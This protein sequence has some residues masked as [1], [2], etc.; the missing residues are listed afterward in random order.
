[1]KRLLPALALL[2]LAG[3]ARA[4][5]PPVVPHFIHETATAGIDSVYA[6][7]W[8]YMVGGGAAAFD[9]NDDG[10]PDLLLAGGEKPAGFFINNSK[11]GGALSFARQ[12]S[13][14]EFE[15][16]TGAYPI[17]I[18][19][20]GIMDVVVLRVGEN[21]VMKGEG[22]C[23]FTRA[24]E[25]WGFDGGDAWSTAFA[26]SWE[27]GAQ[28]PSL[29][30]GNYID[31]NEELEPWGSCTPNWLHRPAAGG[32]GFAPPLPLTP[33]YCP[34]S[35][36]FTDWSNSGAADLRVSN[37]REYYEG[38]QE[39]MWH[40]PAGKPPKLYSK[41]EGWRYL[42]IWGMG[43]AAYDLNHD[44]YQEYFLT[45]MAD[46][47]L[48]TLGK[49]PPDG[50]PARPDYK[51][52]AWP[53]GVTA[54]RPFMGGDLRPS[55]AWHTEF[56]DVNNDGLADLFVAKG[57][58]S[59]M[60]D[61]AMADPNNLLVQGADGKFAEMADKAGVASV[62][63]ARGGAVVDFNLD[64]L[65]DLLVVN[66]NSAAEIWRNATPNAGN[67]LALRLNQPG[68][69]RDG[70]GAVVEIKTRG[71]VQRREITAGGGHVSG[72]AGWIHAGIGA[73][74][75]AEV[76]VRWPGEG[77]SSAITVPANSFAIVEKAAATPRLWQPER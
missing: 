55:T 48:Q 26:A 19:S 16:V 53:A 15:A 17:D 74:D 42:R 43:I 75:Q 49:P 33:S 51:D 30:I 34:L 71:G 67:W 4:A 8:Q 58:V 44:G 69:N 6:G 10:F 52:V 66:R 63:Q 46:N 2:A 41:A 40:V 35:M 22:Q 18:D 61:F 60:P 56:Q 13:G 3:Q 28:W 32:K 68:T 37:D 54:H 9:C 64:G 47:K 77:W 24:N 5:E 73:A 1:M 21:I 36:L 57:N 59:E 14:L 7:Q 12:Q 50:G 27:Q 29:A 20:D 45:S 62:A 11:R 38:G 65:V 31:R 23:R 76:R 72:H 70:I 39:Q 25:A